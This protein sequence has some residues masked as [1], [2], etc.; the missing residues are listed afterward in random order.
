MQNYILIF[1][2]E[3]EKKKRLNRRRYL[4]AHRLY[5]PHTKT[6]FNC[7]IG[8]GKQP[9]KLSNN[10]NTRPGACKCAKKNIIP[11][12]EADEKKKPQNY[13]SV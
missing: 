4:R 11:C 1:Y 12:E 10:D 6:Y 2:A 5:K 13:K 3:I 7:A 8:L 9:L